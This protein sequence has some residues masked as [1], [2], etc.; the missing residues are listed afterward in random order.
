[1]TALT[2]YGTN[3]ATSTLSTAAGLV[4]STGGTLSSCSSKIGTS[5]GYGELYS[6]TN[7]NAWAAAGSLGSP[8]G[9]GWLWDVTS[10][11]GQSL[12]TGNYTPSIR[13]RFSNGTGTCD[14]YV[15]YYKYHSGTY[16]LIGICSSTGNSMTTGFLN[17]TFSATSLNLM[18]FSTGD[19]L[20]IDTWADITANSSG[21]GAA[22]LIMTVCSTSTLGDTTNQSVTPGYLAS[23]FTLT[24]DSMTVSDSYTPTISPTLTDSNTLSDTLSPTTASS[25]TDTSTVSDALSPTSIPILTDALTLVE[26]SVSWSLAQTQTDSNTLTDTPA[27]TTVTDSGSFVDTLSPTTNSTGT[28]SVTVSDTLSPTVSPTVTDSNNF[29]DTLAPSTSSSLT[30]SGLT[31]SDSFSDAIASSLTDSTSLTDTYTYSSS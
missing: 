21:S 23:S 7:S 27:S 3:V 10:L 25:F 4:T 2:V 31:S 18:P 16:T 12:Q 15:R 11:E 17:L 5:T 8:S 19:K 22:T 24:T 9:N 26:S 30:D 14:F 13:V 28:D 1:M 20:Y 29:S 6:L